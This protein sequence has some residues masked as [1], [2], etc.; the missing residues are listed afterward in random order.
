MIK[1]NSVTGH[2]IQQNAHEIVFSNFNVA[3]TLKRHDY[4][5]L[6]Q[7]WALGIKDTRGRSL[8]GVAFT[9]A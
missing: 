5:H 3:A 8:I 4:L 1:W 6:H 7:C 9:H 2:H